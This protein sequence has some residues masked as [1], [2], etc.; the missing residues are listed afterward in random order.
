MN[1]WL[2]RRRAAEQARW[3]R[4]TESS[5]LWLDTT[6]DRR[7]HPHDA[8]PRPRPPARRASRRAH[9][10]PRSRSGCSSY[11]EQDGTFQASIDQRDAGED[12]ANEFVFYDGPPFAN[13]LP[14][15]GHLLTGYVKDVV[16][17][18]Q[19][20]RGRRV[21]RRF[22]WDTHGLPAELEAMRLNGIKTTDEILELGIEKFNEACRAS[23]MKYTGEWR[24]YVTRQARW[25]DFDHDYRTYEPDYME[26][27][28]WAFKQLYD[29]GYVYEGFRVLPYCW[30]DETPLSNHELR[31]DDDVY[32]MRQDPAVTVGFRITS[33]GPL[34][35]ALLL[36]WTTTPWTLPQQPRGHGR[37]GRSTTSWSSTR[38][39]RLRARR[40][41]AAGV[42]PGARA[43][44]P[45]V[46]WRGTGADLV[47]PDLRAAV[48]LLRRP[49]ERVPGRR[50]PTSS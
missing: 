27:V 8:T 50:R 39:T 34:R 28:I 31:M 26:S 24:D 30:N 42:R 3:Y 17:R 18:Y 6:T 14:H 35:D 19:T 5:S 7:R 23:V 49:R 13:G 4:G 47:G 32:Q 22:G 38:A 41:A 16:P 1:E 10:S 36:T 15:Y 40:G 25:V 46:V 12:G 29:K 20:M 37:H 2:A 33:D 48:L 9:A 44:S 43:T 45:D 21:E 11:W